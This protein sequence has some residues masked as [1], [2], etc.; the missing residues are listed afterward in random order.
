MA[1][2]RA[3]MTVAAPIIQREFDFTL[4]EM[5]IILT[6][7]TWAYA[8]FQVPGGLV[9]RRL[10]PRRTLALAGLWWS[11]F[12]F[13][14]PYA[15]TILMF[16]VLR[17]LLGAG[18]AADW[19]ASVT[20][21]ARWFP[22]EERSRANSF[23]LGGI[24]MGSFLGTPIVV[25]IAG[26]HGWQAPFHVF[27]VIGAV[28]AIVWW[29]V[30]GPERDTQSSEEVDEAPDGGQRVRTFLRVP[31]FW[32][33]GLQYSFL[34]LIISFFNIWMPTYLVEAR[35][36]SFASMGPLAAL[37]WGALVATVFLS[38][39]LNDRLIRDWADRRRMAVIGFIVAAIA[40][41]V[42]ALTPSVAG[43]LIW[44]CVSL[45]A[46]GFVQTQVWAATQDYGGVNVPAVS[47]F[48]NMCGIAAGALGPILT[49]LLV[50]IGGNWGIALAV[51]G[52][53][54]ALGAICWM[55]LRPEI[56][57]DSHRSIATP[58]SCEEIA[59]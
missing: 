26:A 29:F 19:P 33:L 23:L 3:A 2:D 4:T 32:L 49:T 25:A 30:Y 53:A 41:M 36:I 20:A 48:V 51:L 55:F 39:I 31:G 14:T 1:V 50:G 8:L 35:G 57:L 59:K 11:F 54:S 12:T 21:I 22:V 17:I 45:G 6:A 47:A 46:V 15:A 56:P 38:G 9:T 13:V 37:P 40:L 43:M 34:T 44:M 27:A 24:Y 16:V 10:G 42:G 58:S 18:Q 5:S 52:A 7:F 28:L